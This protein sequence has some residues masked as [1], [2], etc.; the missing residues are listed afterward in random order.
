M[1]KK[2]KIND[3]ARYAFWGKKI[4]ANAIAAFLEENFPEG[5]I[6]P[7]D[8]LELA[9]PKKSPIHHIFEW[10]DSRAA[11]KFRLD[12]A[13]LLIRC[14][15]VE[16]DGTDVRQYVS[17]VLVH[18]T[19]TDKKYLSVDSAMADESI[20]E[21]VLNRALRELFTWKAQ[22]KRLKKLGPVIKAIEK[23]EEK[24]EKDRTKGS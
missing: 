1:K 12:Q 24:Y 19:D 20:W 13:R 21:Q 4:E 23:L 9:R 5:A 14:L 15:V 8:L 2:F 6:D 3:R 22:Y 10:D 11:E 17:P 7:K 18:P 16:I